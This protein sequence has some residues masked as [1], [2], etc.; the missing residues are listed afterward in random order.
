MLIT[1][2]FSYFNSLDIND[3]FA[4]VSAESSRLVIT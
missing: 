3:N 4:P 1:V 2:L